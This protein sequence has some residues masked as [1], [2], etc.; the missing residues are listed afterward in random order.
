MP[1]RVWTLTYQGARAGG[2]LTHTAILLVPPSL[3]LAAPGVQDVPGAP[4]VPEGWGP[5]G[6]HSD[7]LG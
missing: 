5:W 3:N 6:N 4:G 7:T 2:G 1:S